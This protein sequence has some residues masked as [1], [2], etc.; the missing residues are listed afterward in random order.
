[1]SFPASQN[2]HKQHDQNHRVLPTSRKFLSGVDRLES[3]AEAPSLDRCRLR[4]RRTP[5]REAKRDGFDPDVYNLY[6][7]RLVSCKTHLAQISSTDFEFREIFW[8]M[9]VL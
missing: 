3:S 6:I 2:L 7:L 4:A 8:F 9:R 5:R 1:M